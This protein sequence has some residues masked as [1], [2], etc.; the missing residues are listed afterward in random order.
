MNDNKKANAELD[1]EAMEQ[2]SGGIGMFSHTTES[3]YCDACR[4][5]TPWTFVN[6]A[7]RCTRCMDKPFVEAAG[8][9]SFI[10]V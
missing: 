1:A 9:Q 7:M 5:Y 4:D 3:R 6:G 8:P 10:E 2:V